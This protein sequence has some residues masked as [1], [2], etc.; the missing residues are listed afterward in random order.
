MK[1]RIERSAKC[2]RQKARENGRGMKLRVDR[3]TK[4]GKSIPILIVAEQELPNKDLCF[5]CSLAAWDK[6]NGITPELLEK[7][8]KEDI[9]Q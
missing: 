1:L 2:G 8:R 7:L 9:D 5:T 4:C 3:C 6:K